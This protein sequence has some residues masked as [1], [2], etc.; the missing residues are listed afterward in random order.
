MHSLDIAEGAGGDTGQAPAMIGAGGLASLTPERREIQND[1]CVGKLN[2]LRQVWVREELLTMVLPASCGLELSIDLGFASSWAQW[3]VVLA[4]AASRHVMV[5][6][7]S[8]FAVFITA[9]PTVTRE[10]IIHSLSR[11][12]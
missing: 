1:K 11:I 4:A 3:S 2:I 12:W 5:E 8:P 6:S 10:S 9:Q 7:N